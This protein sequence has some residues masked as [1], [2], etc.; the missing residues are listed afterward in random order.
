MSWWGWILLAAALVLAYGMTFARWRFV[1]HH[2]EAHVLPKG[3]KAIRVLHISDVHMAPWQKRK[4][5]FIK[6]LMS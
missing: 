4:Q 2:S 3:A 5:A 6:S 1:I